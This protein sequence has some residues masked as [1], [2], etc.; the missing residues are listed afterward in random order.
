MNA[1]LVVDTSGDALLQAAKEGVFLLKPNLG[2][3]SALAGKDEINA[4]QV[5][6][7]ARDVINSGQC[8][9]IIVS[10]GASGAMLVTKSEVLEVTPPVVKRK[11]TVG[12]G[13]SMVAGVVLSLARGRSLQE[14]L[15]YGVACGTA[16]TLNPGT[17]LCRLEDVER[18]LRVIK[19]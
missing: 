1:K 6:D 8:E 13:D 9:M 17:E 4:E 11:S 3:L 2:E 19:K 14:A 12:A 5:D 10:L 16:A 15:E 18:L 7:L